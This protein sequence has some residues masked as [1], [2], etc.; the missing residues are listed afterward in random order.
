MKKEDF[1]TIFL[2]HLHLDVVPEVL[3]MVGMNFSLTVSIYQYLSVSIFVELWKMVNNIFNDVFNR[4]NRRWIMDKAWKLL[5]THISLPF[6]L[7]PP[8]I[9]AIATFII[10]TFVLCSQKSKSRVPLNSIT[11]IIY[12][13]LC[14]LFLFFS[15]Q[16]CSLGEKKNK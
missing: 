9:N 13:L 3:L 4:T 5:T 14:P 10:L 12:N 16:Y 8:P 1:V 2:V 11:C 7:L 15:F 6:P